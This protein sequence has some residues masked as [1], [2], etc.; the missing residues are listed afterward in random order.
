MGTVSSQWCTKYN[1]P[2]QDDETYTKTH[3]AK[4]FY[5]FLIASDQF[6]GITK[7][8]S[9]P[10]MW[11]SGNGC[12]YS[13]GGSRDPY[14]NVTTKD[15][16]THASRELYFLDEGVAIGAVDRSLLIGGA[17]P[18]IGE[19]NFSNPLTGVTVIQTI[20]VSI[21]SEQIVDRVKNCNRPSGALNITVKDANEIIL[22]YKRAFESAWS[23]GWDN[24]DDGEIQ[25]VGYYDCKWLV[26]VHVL[27]CQSVHCVQC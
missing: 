25:F 26:Y 22:S 10:Y 13:L 19:Y 5:D 18:A 1:V 9:N 11:T 7:G 2:F 27:N 3:F 17:S 4:M 16:L 23:A 12:D 6:L 21:T 8:K 15:I 20:Y 14:T 24:G